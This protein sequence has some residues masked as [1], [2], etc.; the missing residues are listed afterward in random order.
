VKKTINITTLLL[1][2]FWISSFSQRF[3]RESEHRLEKTSDQLF[4]EAKNLYNKAKY[5]ECARDLVILLDFYS[6]YSKLDQVIYI[7]GDCLYEIDLKK[8]AS[9]IYKHLVK[10]YI[11]SPHLANA[12]LGLQRIE[13]DTNNYLKCIEFYKVIRRAHASSEILDIA[14]YYAGLSYSKMNNYENAIELLNQMSEYGLYYD[15]GLYALA[16]CY[17]RRRQVRQAL[18]TFHKITSLNITTQSRRKVVDETYL[19]LGYIYYE[20]GYFREALEQFNQVSTNHEEYSKALIAAGWSLVKLQR[21]KDALEPLTGI[22]AFAPNSEMAEESMFL[23][24]RCYIKLERYDEALKVYDRLMEIF[25]RRENIPKLV[26][27]VSETLENESSN[28]EKMK[29]DLLMLETKLIDVLSLGK[30]HDIPGYLKEEQQRLLDIRHGLL[31]RIKEERKTIDD[32]SYL[33]ENL[34]HRT[35]IKQDRRDWRA[36]AEYGRARAA[37]LKQLKDKADDRQN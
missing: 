12:L 29:L 17:M 3:D 16:T 6:G 18:D 25:P 23:L 31:R 30:L 5:W 37:F 2:L 11:N 36:Y 1:C 9:K 14:R 7:L 15:Y 10:K 20:L 27:Q 4:Y 22:L 19:T 26:N 33:M 24:G 35:R 21:Y 32:L 13:Y 8:A 34:R 28:L